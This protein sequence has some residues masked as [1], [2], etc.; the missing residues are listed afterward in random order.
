M[1]IAFSVKCAVMHDMNLRAKRMMVRVASL[2]VM[3]FASA[4]CLH[5]GPVP[6][7]NTLSQDAVVP[8]PENTSVRL[9]S[10][11]R[12][13]M[14]ADLSALKKTKRA[15]W[16]FKVNMDLRREVG[17]T[18]DFYCSDVLQFTGFNVY[19]HSGNGWYTAAFSPSESGKWHRITVKKNAF[20]KTEGKV[21]GWGKIDV[22]RIAG[23]VGGKSKVD[24]G[25]ANLS[26]IDHKGPAI[27]VVRPDSCISNPKYKAHYLTLRSCSAEMVSVLDFAGMDA[28]EISDLDLDRETLEGVKLLVFPFNPAIPSDKGDVVKW[29]VKVGGKIFACHS[30]DPAVRE[31]LGLD[32]VKYNA[33]N[34]RSSSETPTKEKGGFYLQHVWRYPF[35]DSVRQAYNLLV[36]VDPSWKKFL[37]AA[38]V[39]TEAAARKDQEW[40]ASL[41]SKKGEWRAFWCHSA[42]GLGNGWNWDASI[43][44]LKENGFNAIVPNLAWGGSAFY[45]SSVLPVHPSVAEEGDAFDKCIRA[46]RR[47]GVECHVWK[48]CWNMRYDTDPEVVNAMLDAGRTQVGFNG[49]RKEKWLCPSHPENQRMQREAFVEMA[50]KGPTGIHFDYIRYPD[51]EHCFCD[52]CRARFENRIG[53]TVRNWPKDIRAD[54][55]LAAE[56]IAFRCSNITAIVREVSELVR[57]EFPEVRISAAVF[58]NPEVNP[59][60]IAQDWVDW[61]RSG[62]LDFICPMNYYGGSDLAFK[63]LVNVQVKALDG[64]S[65]KIRPGLGLSCWKD[66]SRDAVTMARQIMIVREAGLD[67]FCVFN[68]DSRAEKVLPKIHA[69]PVK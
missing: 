59:R 15:G 66:L 39:K 55:S 69:G 6:V 54:K 33:R 56:W 40:V 67:G 27:G 58:H 45:K 2:A 50:G 1:T 62:Y 32:A 11:G 28:V 23:W 10:P 5:A 38:K 61:C 68:F 8:L 51:M 65:T 14:G 36:Q 42:R 47:Y 64:C 29:F 24:F 4:P 43:K 34:W 52:G 25:V 20:F 35:D 48:V 63:G 12:F 37:D 22:M 13:L 41:P 7:W 49:E 9:E 60:D 46:C 53:R 21:H 30:Q 44:F 57:R 31:A 19:L 18:F 3:V 17:F 26:Y 16:D